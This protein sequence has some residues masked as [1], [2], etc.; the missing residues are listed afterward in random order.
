VIIINLKKIAAYNYILYFQVG[1]GDL[2]L[3][4]GLALSEDLLIVADAAV[5]VYDIE[6]NLKTTL[7]P[8]PKGKFLLENTSSMS[9]ATNK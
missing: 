9:T 2:G 7:A 3:V 5:R 6:G 4:G 1:N 8:V